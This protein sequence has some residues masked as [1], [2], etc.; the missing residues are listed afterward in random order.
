M[1]ELDEDDPEI[2]R[3]Q[4][5]TTE[6]NEEKSLS[7]RLQKFSDW[8]RAVRAIARLK[9]LAKEARGLQTRSNEATTLEERKDAEQFSIRSRRSIQL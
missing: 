2:K 1:G 7:D 3:A 8:K 5:H 4:V 6:A 9:R